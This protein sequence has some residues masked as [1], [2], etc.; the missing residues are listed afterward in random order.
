MSITVVWLV[1]IFNV[2]SNM[3][4]EGNIVT[5]GMEAKKR[6]RADQCGNYKLVIKMQ[7]FPPPPTPVPH[8]A[9]A[10]SM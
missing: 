10:R 7:L 4:G 2:V 9:V 3:W 8:R 5:T 1:P 6:T